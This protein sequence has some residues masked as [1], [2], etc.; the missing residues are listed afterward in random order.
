MLKIHF[1]SLSKIKN[2]RNTPVLFI[3][4]LQDSFVPPQQTA[5]LFNGKP[6]TT[7]QGF[8]Q[9][10]QVENGNHN[11]TWLKHGD[12]YIKDL[13]DFFKK[14]KE[15]PIVE[16]AKHYDQIVKKNE[17]MYAL[18]AVA[19]SLSPQQ[20]LDEN[21]V[22]TLRDKYADRMSR[23]QSN[24]VDL[25]VFEELFSFAC[26]KFISPVP[27]ALDEEG[28]PPPGHNPQEAYRLQLRLFMA[29]VVQQ[30]QLPTI[31]SYLKLYTT[32]G[33]PK[34]AALAE[35][36]EATFREHLQSL[37]H[38]THTMSWSGGAPLSGSWASS[39]EVDFFV[40]GDVAHVADSNLV[41]KHS[42]YF[43]KQINKLEEIIS[44]LK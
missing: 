8:K 24:A 27:P 12:Q 30:K 6:G 41:R 4:G 3:T 35:A 25:T 16:E 11:D 26:P 7:G 10:L 29:E 23:M 36:D 33:I 31:R 28:K 34:L 14:A 9:I 44:T 13:R 5:K 15:N 17:Q 1:D 37:K 18:L 40:E 19:A 2:V 43:V 21:L 32:I 22:S 20:A 42:D 39:A 38:K